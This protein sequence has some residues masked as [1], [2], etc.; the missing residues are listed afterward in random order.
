MLV[1]DLTGNT[2]AERLRAAMPDDRTP[3]CAAFST[4]AQL[5]AVGDDTG[6][7]GV[8]SV[9]ERTFLGAFD[10]GLRRPVR[11]VVFC[12]DNRF[13]AAPTATG[14]GVWAVGRSEV[15][16]E[17]PADDRAVFRLLPQGDRIVVAGRDGA[18]RVWSLGGKE[19][20]AMFG[21]VGRVT[22][23]GVAPNGR[24][25]VSGGATGEVRFWDSRTGTELMSLRRHS[26]AVTVV[27]FSID[28]RALVTAGDGQ[29]AVWDARE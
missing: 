15:V 1:R 26:S 14:V 23:L 20:L 10:T 24:T 2:G 5:V 17:V 12:D 22:G 29:F 7:V 18:V 8:W 16:V 13:V 11:R 25:I 21:H 3:A 9:A 19:E 4:D 28:G 6:R 27:E